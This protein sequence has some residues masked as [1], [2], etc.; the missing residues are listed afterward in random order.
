MNEIQ[1]S[2]KRPVGMTILLVLSL[3]NACLQIFSAFGM[4]IS[5]PVMSQMMAEGSLEE[6]MAPFIT[7][8]QLEGDALDE[9]WTIIENRLT[10]N[11][12]YYLLIAVCYI[13]SLVGVLKMFKLQRLGFHIYS[14]A[15]MLILIVSVIYIYS[16]QGQNTFFNEFL[17][18]VMLILLYHLYFK[19]IEHEKPTES[20]E[21]IQPKA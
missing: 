7:M 20:G 18:T 19:R 2:P 11:P 8:M 14:I 10:I 17:T 9:F 15:Q 16:H 13:G 3:I 4:Y 12:I 21:D 1:T 6:V 5:T